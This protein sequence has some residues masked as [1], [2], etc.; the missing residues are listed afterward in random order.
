MLLRFRE[1]KAQR[2]GGRGEIACGSGNILGH[3][4]TFIRGYK[5]KEEPGQIAGL[6]WYK[7]KSTFQVLSNVY[8]YLWGVVVGLV[9]VAWWGWRCFQ[10]KLMGEVSEKFLG[11]LLLYVHRQKER[12]KIQLAVAGHL[13]MLL[14]L[15]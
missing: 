13:L 8:N 4:T 12:K 14:L 7:Y 2:R 6:L 5:S 15:A 1:I 9:P 11:N 3:H 10:W